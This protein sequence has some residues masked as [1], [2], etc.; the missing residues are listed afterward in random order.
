MIYERN[1]CKEGFRWLMEEIDVKKGLEDK[2]ND[3]M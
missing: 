1:E 3:W 2:W